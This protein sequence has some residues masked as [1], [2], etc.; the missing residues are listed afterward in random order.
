MLQVR[1]QYFVH[2]LQVL[3]WH[4]IADFVQNEHFRKR[5]QRSH[6][7]NFDEIIPIQQSQERI[8]RNLGPVRFM[9]ASGDD[10]TQANEFADIPDFS[11]IITTNLMEKVSLSSIK[12]FLKFVI[13]S[14]G[15]RTL[16]P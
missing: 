1:D 4:I 8:Q 5:E 7:P 12:T 6:E 9:Y 14:K 2:F 10:G 11:R 13:S 16:K 15:V 3:Y